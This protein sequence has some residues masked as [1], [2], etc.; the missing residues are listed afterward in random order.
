MKV[1]NVSVF[2][3]QSTCALSGNSFAYFS[4]K[5]MYIFVSLLIY[6]NAFYKTNIMFTGCSIW[7]RT[8]TL[9]FFSFDKHSK[10]DVFPNVLMLSVIRNKKIL[11]NSEQDHRC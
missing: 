7:C 8:C 3:N 10:K 4:F 6:I 9:F 11:R 2:I 5:E 1:G